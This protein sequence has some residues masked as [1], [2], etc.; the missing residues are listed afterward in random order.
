MDAEYWY[1][2]AKKADNIK[3]PTLTEKARNFIRATVKHVATGMNLVSNEIQEKRMTICK[4]C[5]FYDDNNQNPHC[6][7]CGCFLNIKTT[8]ASEGCPVGKWEAVATT[9][10]GGSNCGGC[11]RQ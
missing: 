10:R 3:S 2:L 8:W 1:N 6:S 7:K 5:E 4:G 11:G 9:P